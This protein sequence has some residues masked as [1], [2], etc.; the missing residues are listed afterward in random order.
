MSKVPPNSYKPFGTGVRS[1]IGRAFAE[2]E[3]IAA[4]ALILQ[5]FQIEAA[6]PSYDLQLKSTLT[7]KPDHF[8]FK[9][10]RRPGVGS[11]G[12]Q[13]GGSTK[14][15]QPQQQHNK[16]AEQNASDHKIR[17]L[18]GNELFLLL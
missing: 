16:G 6:D 3:M 1:C 17:V 10:R 11:I 14:E 4:V 9:V 7:I 18:Y 2:Q 5:R 8:K 13:L 15:A 12:M